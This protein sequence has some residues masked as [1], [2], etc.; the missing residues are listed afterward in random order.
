M[1]IDH[2]PL[3]RRFPLP[4]I[5]LRMAVATLIV[6]GIAA[7]DDTPVPPP[8]GPPPGSCV[9]NGVIYPDGTNNL[10]ASDGCNT[11]S[12]SGGSL[13]CTLRACPVARACGARA[14][15]TCAANEYCAYVEGEYC[16]GA[17]AEAVCKTRPVACDEVYAPV[18]GCD[19]KTYANA[20]NAAAAGTGVLK[21][22]GC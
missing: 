19:G 9:V 16:G 15:N 5:S 13:Q 21:A 20:C 10:P 17:D 11:C 12:C 2:A 6:L 18:C 3:P 14:G 22:G 8:G 7:C 4:A 1:M